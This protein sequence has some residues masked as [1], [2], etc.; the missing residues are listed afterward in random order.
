MF[1]DNHAQRLANETD[2]KE[3]NKIV[4][5][6]QDELSGSLTSMIFS[7]DRSS[8]IK[9]H[10]GFNAALSIPFQGIPLNENTNSSYASI[11]NNTVAAA[12]LIRTS[13]LCA[14]DLQ[15][16]SDLHLYMNKFIDFQ[17]LG[18]EVGTDFALVYSIIAST[19]GVAYYS[20]SYG[21]QV[22]IGLKKIK[23]FGQIIKGYRN[24]DY[25][26]TLSLTTYASETEAISSSGASYKFSRLDGG[27]KIN[28][29]RDSKERFLRLFYNLEMPDY[30]KHKKNYWGT[31]FDVKGWLDISFLIYPTY[32]ST[33]RTVIL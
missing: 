23:I 18:K 30:V 26:N 19:G 15:L 17:L 31:G 13:Q 16:N 21:R 12:T 22:D 7:I 25:S 6:Q 20:F 8:L 1:L 10:T 14:L 5:K 11:D 9:K 4:A 27:V 32:P 33:G 29:N 24:I 2:I 3:N 28:F